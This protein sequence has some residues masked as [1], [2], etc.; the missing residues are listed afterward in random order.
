MIFEQEQRALLNLVTLLSLREGI[1]RQKLIQAMEKSA[2]QDERINLATEL[3]HVKREKI[4]AYALF[5][6]LGLQS[7]TKIQPWHHCRIHE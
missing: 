7:K 5:Q 4:K 1:A 2:E 6:Y 3:L